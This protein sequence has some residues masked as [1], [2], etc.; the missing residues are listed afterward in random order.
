[1]DDRVELQPQ[2]LPGCKQPLGLMEASRKPRVERHKQLDARD[3]GQLMQRFF[4]PANVCPSNGEERPEMADA[5]DSD[6]GVC[7]VAQ[8]QREVTRHL[9]LRRL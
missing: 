6:I 2:T 5:R 4:I 8:Q 3:A 1:M 7:T 9:G